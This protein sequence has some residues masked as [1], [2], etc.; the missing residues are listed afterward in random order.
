[1]REEAIIMLE[2][3][4]DARKYNSSRTRYMIFLTMAIMKL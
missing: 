3:G 4:L 1:M 2:R